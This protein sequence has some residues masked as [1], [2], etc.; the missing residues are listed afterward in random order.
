MLLVKKYKTV[1]TTAPFIAFD[2]PLEEYYK[3]HDALL[4]IQIHKTIERMPPIYQDTL[5]NFWIELHRFSTQR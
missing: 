5:N 4:Y 1:E 2:M 3:L